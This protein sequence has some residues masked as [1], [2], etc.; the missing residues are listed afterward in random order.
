VKSDGR[1]PSSLGVAITALHVVSS[2]DVES[3]KYMSY[4]VPVHQVMRFKNGNAGHE[5]EARSYQVITISNPNYIWI[6]IVGK[7]NGIAVVP[8]V[9]IASSSP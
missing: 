5:V 6:G 4:D 1:R 3:R 9:L 2:V 7:E 8:V